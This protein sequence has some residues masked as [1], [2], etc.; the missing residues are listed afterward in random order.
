MTIRMTKVL[1]VGMAGLVVLA[2]GCTSASNDQRAGAAPTPHVHP[3]EPIYAFVTGPSGPDQTS[4]MSVANGQT[5]LKSV[6]FVSSET[7]TDGADT[8]SLIWTLDGE[9]AVDIDYF[10]PNDMYGSD[11]DNG[12]QRKLIAI[13]KDGKAVKEFTCAGCAQIGAIGGSKLVVGVDR[14][15]EDQPAQG[16]PF[17]GNDVPLEM[18][19]LNSS[20]PPVLMHSK[21]P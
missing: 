18:V 10:A 9:W 2:V 8:S 13:R 6:P 19:D 15:F 12:P 1:G 5:V 20:I 7:G 11:V 16:S 21:L 4:T 3:S 14:Q 17:P